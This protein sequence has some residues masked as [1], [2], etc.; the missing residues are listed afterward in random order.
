M[1]IREFEC[2]KCGHRQEQIVFGKIRFGPKCQNCGAGRMARVM[3]AAWFKFKGPGFYET[4]YKKPKG[5]VHE[6]K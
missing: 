5:S 1:P 3:S 4:D 6:E 2:R